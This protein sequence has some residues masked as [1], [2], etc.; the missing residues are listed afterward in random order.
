M[1]PPH[2]TI[3][4]LINT[5]LIK[6]KQIMKKQL[7]LASV[8]MMGLSPVMMAQ[9]P[10]PGDKALSTYSSNLT[11]EWYAAPTGTCADANAARSGIGVNGKFYVVM[12]NIGVAVFDKDG[13]VKTIDNPTAWVS[14]NCD[15]AGHVYFRN[16]KGG[17]PGN[18]AGSF[19]GANAQ[20]CVIDSKTDEIIKPNVPMSATFSARFDALPHLFGDMVNDF[21][22]VAVT[23]NAGSVSGIN[24]MYDKLEQTGSESINFA[25]S[26]KD[27]GFPAP[28]NTVQTLGQAQFFSPDADGFSTKLAVLSNNYNGAAVDK[29][30][31]TTASWFGWGNNVALYTWTDDAGYAFTG[32]WYNTPSHSA[33]GGF[34]MFSYAGKDYICYPAGTTKDG[35]PS[36]DGFFVMEEELVD[37]PQNKT[38]EEDPTLWSDE[39]HK[40]VAT[41]YATEGIATG[42]NYRG[43]N[44]EPVAGEDGK[45]TIYHY[46]PAKSMEVWTLDLTGSAAGIEDIVADKDVAKIFG[47][48]GVVVTDGTDKAQ[49][50]NMAG[51]LV[52]VGAGHIAVE[53][54]VYVV[55]AGATVAKVVVR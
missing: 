23:A 55:K 31:S 35:Y 30:E 11:L 2:Q 9:L 1:H 53:A 19:N 40:A 14:I 16:D 10:N 20:F 51:Q 4:I 12:Q 6:Q 18:P 44:V 33:V 29:P 39:L 41:K 49:V 42:N 17:W 7:L 27:G 45:F 46:N 32:K 48:V 3:N 26:L 21:I 37:T 15:D 22:E 50:Y 8:A 28:A 52:A 5:T 24:F 25:K 13:K 47:G 43:I 34:C 38:M 36:G 54:G